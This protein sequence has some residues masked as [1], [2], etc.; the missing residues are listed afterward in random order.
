MK[1]VSRIIRDAI[2]EKRLILPGRELKW[3][4]RFTREL[5]ECPD[6]EDKI[7]QTQS[8]KYQELFIPEEYGLKSLWMEE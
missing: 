4:D 7:V 8:K 2:K 3:L 5:E 6:D 1:A